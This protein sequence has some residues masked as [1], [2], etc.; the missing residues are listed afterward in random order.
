MILGGGS[1]DLVSSLGGEL[2]MV[3]LLGMSEDDAVKAVVVL[4]TGQ[5]P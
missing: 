2:Q 5:A 3:G 1:A 4:Q